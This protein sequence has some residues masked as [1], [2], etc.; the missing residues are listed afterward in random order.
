MPRVKGAEEEETTTTRKVVGGV[1]VSKGPEA[2]KKNDDP[3]KKSVTEISGVNPSIKR[4]ASRQIQKTHKGKDDAGSKQ[5]EVEADGYNYLNVVEPPYNLEYLAKLPELSPPHLAAIQAKIANIV[6]LGWRLVES[7]KMKRKLDRT[8]SETKTANLRNKLSQAR[9]EITEYIDELNDDDSLTD[10]L[11]KVWYDYE[12]IGQGYLEI[13]RGIDGRIKYIG[14]IPAVSMRVRRNRDGYVQIATNKAVYFRNFGEDT[15]NPLTSDQNPN[16]IIMFKKYCATNS[17]YGLPDIIAATQAIAGNEFSARYNLDYFENKAVPRHVIVLKGAELSSVAETRIVEF[18]DTSLKGQNHRSLYVPLPGDSPDEK[19][20]LEI[21]PVEAGVQEQ[22]FEK[23]RKSNSGE[24]FLAHRVP[25][26]KTGVAE[27]VSVAAALSA[28]K[29][30]KDEVCKPEQ[31]FAE[32]KVNKIIKELTDV[33]VLELNELTL[34][35]EDTQSKIDE[36]YLRMQV[37]TPNMVL[38]RMGKPG[39]KGGDKPV[40][41]KPQQAADT[42]A[43]AG[44]TRARDGER[45]AATSTTDANG[46]G[47]KGEGRVTPTSTK[48]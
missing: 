37:Y 44:Q 16:E 32:R 12:A 29:T 20:S 47:P 17:W 22:S 25:I 43:Q 15:P 13:S 8:E 38:Q 41:L 7:P 31:K 9:E 11:S 46:R 10:T 18:F 23:Y 30:F 35:D 42:R 45:S 6:G 34:T 3:F 33:F 36:R 28:A 40:D 26:S 5:I 19:V 4:K 2:T 14:H 39:R 48:E 24:I 1:K 21:K 27:G